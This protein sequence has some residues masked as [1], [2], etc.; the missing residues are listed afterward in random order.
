MRY[1]FRMAK[2]RANKNAGARGGQA[3]LRERLRENEIGS[4]SKGRKA[5]GGE[6]RGRSGSRR[7]AGES[8]KARPAADVLPASVP[9]DPHG[10]I[11]VV[12]GGAAGLAAAIAAGRELERLEREGACAASVRPSIVVFEADER[13]GRSILA[14]GNGRCN[15]SNARIDAR[16]YRNAAFVGEALSSLG[17]RDSRRLRAHGIACGPSE[18]PVLRFFEGAGL[19]LREEGEG[20]LYP[21]T[22]KASTV[23]DVLR[24]VAARQG[25]VEAC[26]RRAV[27]IEPPRAEGGLFHLRFSDRTIEHAAAM[28]VALGGKHALTGGSPSKGYSPKSDAGRS[29]DEAGGAPRQGAAALL[30]ERYGCEPLR[31]V[32]GPLAVGESDP[33]ALDN[34]RVRARVRLADGIPFGSEKARE[35]G[36]V[37]FRSYGVSGICVF[38]LSR[39]ADAGDGL[40]IDLLPQ[41]GEHGHRRYLHERWDRMA[42]QP[43]Y[44]GP[45]AAPLTNSAF[46]NGLL[47]PQVARAVLKRAGLA[48]D[49]PLGK[50]GIPAL[51]NAL[52]G[53]A[54]T[55][56]GIGD[57]RQCQVMRGGLDVAQFD[58]QT[59]ESRL[60]AGLFA[61]GEALDVDAPCGGYNLH[62][63]WASGMLAGMSAARRIAGAETIA[64]GKCPDGRNLSDDAAAADATE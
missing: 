5:S 44:A 15:L 1:D 53:F 17:E 27:R 30:P 36:E 47:L 12:G 8:P 6:A 24:A 16:L 2:R 32:L 42:S 46:L 45:G 62:W 21:A 50:E 25:A 31:P 58:P 23:L 28:I 57:E 11:A 22:G 4:A 43:E 7:N 18:D 13:V 35:D 59:M 54:L 14:T 29:S 48:P 60:D 41:A 49:A 64:L 40:F 33:R 56:E 63:A 61:A 37:L 20:R 39:F 51:A 19:E 10:R 9:G 34:I 55:V 52:Q 38:N 26:G 3:P